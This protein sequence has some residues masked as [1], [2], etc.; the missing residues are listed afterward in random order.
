MPKDK[1]TKELLLKC[2]TEEFIEKGYKDASLRNICRR[3]GLTTGAMYFFFDGKEDIFNA[4]VEEPVNALM[5]YITNHFELEKEEMQKA[6]Y[7]AKLSGAD[8]KSFIGIT[9]ELSPEDI[10]SSNEIIKIL[11]SN[12]ELVNLIVYNSA[13]TKYEHMIDEVVEIVEKHY[14]YLADGICKVRG[15]PKIDKFSIH[16]IAH[17][18]I[19]IFLYL[20]GHVESEKEALKLSDKIVKILYSS[21]IGLFKEGFV[22]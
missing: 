19:D 12:R 7:Q 6:A 2:A 14:R 16:W 10:S 22:N 20:L 17:E 9:E 13:G 15:I 1:K 21:W 5:S 3:A 8:L 4:V 11:Y 18:Q